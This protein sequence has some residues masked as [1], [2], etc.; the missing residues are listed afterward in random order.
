MVRLRLVRPQPLSDAHLALL[1]ELE[2]L[3]ANDPAHID[4]LRRR[5]DAQLAQVATRIDAPE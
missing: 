2:Q 1:A 4:W 3:S 5:H